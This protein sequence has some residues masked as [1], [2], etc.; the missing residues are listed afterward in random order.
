MFS[1]CY[2]TRTNI[3]YMEYV[4][5]SYP[6]HYFSLG[7]VIDRLGPYLDKIKLTTQIELTSKSQ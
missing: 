6:Y 1:I 3:K 4:H 5:K 2:L 7:T